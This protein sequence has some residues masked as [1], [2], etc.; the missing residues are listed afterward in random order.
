MTTITT[1]L[2]A[3][4]RRTMAILLP[5]LLAAL[6]TVADAQ[7]S[8]PRPAY[9]KMSPLIRQACLSAQRP[10]KAGAPRAGSHGGTGR[11]PSLVAFVK[12]ATGD[13]SSLS[14]NRCR[15]L[16]RYGSLCVA[17]IPLSSIAPLSLDSNVRRIEARRGNTIAMDTTAI[18]INAVPVQRGLDLPQGFTGRGVVVGV[19]DIGFD[20]THPTFWSADMQ[21]YRIKAMWDQLSDDTLA[22]TL[23]VGRDYVGQD[24]LLDVQHPRDGTTQTH[25]TH[26]AGIAAGSGA[27]G[28]GQVSPYRGIAY[29][30][31][32]CLVC[33]ATS[34][35]ISLIDPSDYYK[36]T[37]ATDALGFKYI[38][39]Y[40]DRQ[41]LPCVIN[42]SE[43]SHMD[44]RGDDQLYYE[45]LDSL[46]GPGHIIVASAG[47]DGARTTYVSKEE[48]Q[49]TDSVNLYLDQRQSFMVT[50]R[51]RGDFLMGL[52]LRLGGQRMETAM[53]QADVLA[54]AD[55][56]LTDSLM[57]TGFKYTITA[58]AYP[59]CFDADDIICDW[60][61]T[62]DTTYA[63][64]DTPG[65]LV[66]S[67]TGDTRVELFQVAGLLYH[68]GWQLREG[69]NAY[70]VNSPSSAPAVISVGNTGYR[71]HITN[72][73]GLTS[74]FSGDTSGGRRRGSS[75]VGPTLDGRIKPDVMAPG[76][77]IIS[78]YSSFFTKWQT[79]PTAVRLFPYDGRTYSWN[80]DQGTSMSSPVVAGIIALWLQAYPKLSPTD[81]LDIFAKTCTRPD[82]SAAYPNNQYGHGQI[83]ALA[84]L[85][86][87]MEK[88]AAGIKEKKVDEERAADTRVYTL[89]GIC[90]G[91]EK[92]VLPPGL[93]ITGGRKMVIR[94]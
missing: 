73:A 57:G 6:P 50:T 93:Y 68:D 61:I 94:K 10:T 36:Y 44:F 22:S 81:C 86:L 85:R 49:P 77:N 78:S 69:E 72:Y 88:A 29:D 83:D 47:N 9:N 28:D 38:F 58:T 1:A 12:L 76:Q 27:E 32:I 26:T 54:A 80:A 63:A 7:G 20:L 15:V 43:G 18:I 23:P 5:C 19:Q 16:A 48:G 51:S 35:D 70:G 42:F 13:T 84:G 92:T 91:T 8:A 75:S 55:S 25:G 79:G 34:D 64:P 3:K 24:A 39:D 14:G 11:E 31:D 37:Y 2:I 89:G 52:S 60:L 90:V 45:M 71:T 21:R 82:P 53:R 87:V 65:K 67:M 40:A 41:G 30:A 62:R 74:T 59:S 66:I 4:A 56:T 33:N 17:Q 46:T